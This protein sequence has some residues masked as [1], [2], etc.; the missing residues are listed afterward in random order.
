MAGVLAD[1]IQS[2]SLVD[3][4]NYWFELRE[5]VHM[6]DMEQFGEDM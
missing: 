4:Q 6:A 5:V 1:A 2:H 3:L